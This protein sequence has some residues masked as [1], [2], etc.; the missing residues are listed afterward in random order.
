MGLVAGGATRRAWGATLVAGALGVGVFSAA[1]AGAAT[2]AGNPAGTP[3]DVGQ[4]SCGNGWTGGSAGPLSFALTN[5]SSFVQ[6]VQIQDVSTKKIFVDVEDLGVG[7]TRS[8]TLALPAGSYRFLCMGGS[9]GVAYASATWELTGDYQG[10][11]TPGVLPATELDFIGPVNTYST[12]TAGQLA[13]LETDV[14]TLRTAIAKGDV[15]A[16]RNAWK[17]AHRQYLLLG[18][19]YGA[20]GDAGDAI[21]SPITPGVAPLTDPDLSGFPK[22]EAVL[23]HAR[24]V[25]AVRHAGKTKKQYRKA[26][27]TAQRARRNLDAYLAASAAPVARELASDVAEVATTFNNPAQPSNTDMGLRSHEILEDALRFELTGRDD[28]GAHLTLFDVDAMID[29]TRDIIAPLRGMLEKRDEDL[30]TTDAWLTRLKA[31]VDSF[32]HT[33]TDTWTPYQSLSVA[34]KRK[35]EATL[36]QTLEYLSEIAVVLDPVQ[37]GPA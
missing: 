36:S 14:A 33:A 27:R 26:K 22:L 1:T 5:S 9:D 15:L 23:W 28:A 13:H 37:A 20:F 8:L 29:A 3:V 16:A 19:A 17:T 7:A 34:Q 30:A 6:E 18:A 35:L 21:D 32:H 11:T 2:D 4:A 25:A 12:W 10:A 31:Y 24:P